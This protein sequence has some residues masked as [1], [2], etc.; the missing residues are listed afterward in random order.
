MSLLMREGGSRS[1]AVLTSVA[2]GPL[3]CTDT[4]YGNKNKTPSGSCKADRRCEQ[5]SSRQ[6]RAYA[7]FLERRPA[8]TCELSPGVR[9]GFARRS[10]NNPAKSSSL[11][12][13]LDLLY[14][15]LGCRCV[16]RHEIVHPFARL[17]V[18][19][20]L[21]V[22]PFGSALD[23]YSR[24]HG[25]HFREI[26]QT[27]AVG[28]LHRIVV[29]QLVLSGVEDEPALLPALEQGPPLEQVAL[30]GA[31]LGAVRRELVV[32]RCVHAGADGAAVGVGAL[33]HGHRA[34]VR[35]H[36]LVF[37]AVLGHRRKALLVAV[38]AA[39]YAVHPRFDEA[40]ED[41]GAEVAVRGRGVVV[42]VEAVRVHLRGRGTG[43]A[44]G[45]APFQGATRHLAPHQE[46]DGGPLVHRTA[47]RTHQ[48]HVERR[49]AHQG[50]HD[51]NVQLVPEDVPLLGQ[52]AQG[53]LLVVQTLQ[54]LRED[55]HL[56]STDVVV[57]RVE[58]LAGPSWHQGAPGPPGVWAPLASLQE[59]QLR[60]VRGPVLQGLLQVVLPDVQVRDV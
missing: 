60:V 12:A 20:G 38:V 11:Q 16:G 1:L 24:R 33:G 53:S 34:G 30:V 22:R 4:S 5:T 49:V 55:V 25:D 32:V 21:L 26:N 43:A 29:P 8:G 14:P 58:D 27:L 3:A 57:A 51:G 9:V 13:R 28:I 44:R 52:V 47:V 39:V 17:H 40:P 31:V 42:P 18:E 19:E 48:V 56:E 6:S 54:Q 45:P 10:R 36:R 37:G 15:L 46:L 7:L 23:G 50:V 2:I 35:S 41:A 59:H